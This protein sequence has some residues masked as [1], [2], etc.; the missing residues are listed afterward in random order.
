MSAIG[1]KADITLTRTNVRLALRKFAGQEH[2]Q[3]DNPGQACE[4][5]CVNSH[6]MV[7]FSRRRVQSSAASSDRGSP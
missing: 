6:V 4:V 7:R 1:G 2:G 5:N 3:R